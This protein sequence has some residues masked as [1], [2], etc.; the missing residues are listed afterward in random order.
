MAVFDSE[1]CIEIV[2]K[3]QQKVYSLNAQDDSATLFFSAG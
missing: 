3:I 1:E 2:N